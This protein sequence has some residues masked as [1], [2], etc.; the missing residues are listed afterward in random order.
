MKLDY[1]I[2]PEDVGDE[3]MDVITKVIFKKALDEIALKS[4]SGPAA[5]RVNER[6][7][8]IIAAED[9]IMV[10]SVWDEGLI[11][12]FDDF[13]LKTTTNISIEEEPIM[14]PPCNFEEISEGIADLKKR[15]NKL[16]TRKGFSR[17]KKEYNRKSFRLNKNN[18]RTCEVK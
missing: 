15:H 5:V 10:P 14:F 4:L 6:G 2:K 8:E 16:K 18:F 1:T 3:L 17:L 9:M 13:P 11:N 7:V 12:H